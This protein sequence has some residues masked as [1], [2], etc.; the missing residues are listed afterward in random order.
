MISQISRNFPKK[1]RT[2]KNAI[3][4]YFPNFVKIRKFREIRMEQF[5]LVSLNFTKDNLCNIDSAN[6]SV[7]HKHH[8]TAVG[9]YCKIVSQY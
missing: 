9:G 2:R 4:L 7:N 8:N 3:F 1:N 5:S 6:N